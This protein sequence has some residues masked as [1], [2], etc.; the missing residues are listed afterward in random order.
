MN[1]QDE[2]RLK[3]MRDAALE[4]LS[5]IAGQSRQSLNADLLLVR[6]VSMS[7][8]IIGEAASHISAPFREETPQIPWRQIIGMRNFI[9]HEYPGIDLDVIWDTASLRVPELLTAIKK[10]LSADE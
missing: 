1:E 3:H 2:I 5:F 10:I 7:L 8:G 6:G 4:V 9:I